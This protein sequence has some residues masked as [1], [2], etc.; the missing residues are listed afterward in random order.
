MFY[1]FHIYWM[2][3]LF[4]ARGSIMP[5][6]K[7]PICKKTSKKTSCSWCGTNISIPEA[8]Q[9]VISSRAYTLFNDNKKYID[10][11]SSCKVCITNRR[12]VIYKI[13]PEAENPA[14]GLLK[15]LINVFTK[16]PYISI[17][18]DEIEGVRRYDT[19][20]KIDTK[21][22]TYSVCVS[23][24]KEFDELFTR[25]KQLEEI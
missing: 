15:D 24:F 14:F 9:L 13:R 25:Y 21:T 10:R 1:L 23:K 3:F 16:N 18:L 22:N 7:C 17:A 8:E 4:N 5:K 20:H 19:W 11:Y 2:Q 6:I 12:L